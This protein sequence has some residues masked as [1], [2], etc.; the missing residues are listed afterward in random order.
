MSLAKLRQSEH[1]PEHIQYAINIWL[2]EANLTDIL[3]GILI[4]HATMA[5]L[6]M[7]QDPP[8][9]SALALSNLD[10]NFAFNELNVF[11]EHILKHIEKQTKIEEQK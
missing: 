9:H 3:H 8:L 7:D 10:K 11:I 5:L 6:P 4:A 2:R 1:L